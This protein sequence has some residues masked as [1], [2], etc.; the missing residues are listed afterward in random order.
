VRTIDLITDWSQ[1]KLANI[2]LRMQ[3]RTAANLPRP[4]EF[5]RLPNIDYF[6]KIEPYEGCIGGDYLYFIDFKNYQVDDGIRIQ[7]LVEKA[8]KEGRHEYART[9]ENNLDAIG[10]VI[11]DSAD[12]G[13]GDSVPLT[14]F[15]GALQM[16]I[17]YE[18]L[19]NGHVT[20]DFFRRFNRKYNK[21]IEPEYIRNKPFITMLYVEVH[22]NGTVKF[23]NAGHH[24][25]LVF[26]NFHNRFEDLDKRYLQGSTPLGIMPNKFH[27]SSSGFGTAGIFPVNEITLLG[28]GDILLLYTDGLVEHQNPA[29]NFKDSGLEDVLRKTKVLPAR[30]IYHA[31]KKGLLGY[32]PPKDDYTI[33]V[34]KKN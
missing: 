22:N 7:D 31:I 18:F 25:P 13:I 34:I 24:D 30:D 33:V 26:S 3:E 28:Q 1:P 17:D 6:A 9:L 16:A 4:G 27:T 2:A 29:D 12:H 21:W 14:Y 10:I 32:G 5:P 23:V 20:A 8:R 15:H 11:A 19:L